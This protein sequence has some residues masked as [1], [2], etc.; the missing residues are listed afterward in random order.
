MAQAAGV[1]LVLTNDQDRIISGDGTQHLRN[2]LMME[3]R[4]HRLS[5]AR[6]RARTS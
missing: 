4:G 2:V 6:R 1:F 3:S 5:A